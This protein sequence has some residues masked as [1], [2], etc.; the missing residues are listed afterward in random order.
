VAV[1]APLTFFSKTPIECPIC[2][3]K[4][5]R[6]EMRTGR[7]RQ[8]AGSLT[9]EL[10]RNYE[11]SKQ[12]GEVLPL[13][14]PVTV[15][16][17]CYY[18]TYHEDFLNVPDRIVDTLRSEDR[19]RADF[20]KDIFPALDFTEP[21]ALEEGVASY[22]FASMCYEHF[23]KQ[24]SPL[25]KSGLSQ[26]R[27]AWLCQDLHRKQPAEN[28]DYLARVFYRKA[29]Y[30]YMRAVEG[31]QDGSQT[32]SG[33]HTL[34]P[35]LDKNYGYDGVLYISGLLEFQ[36]GPKSDPEARRQALGRAKRTV[37]RIF[38][39]GKASKDKPAAI[40]DNARE[41]YDAISK[42]LGDAD[43]APEV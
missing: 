6:E 16:P 4:V 33:A 17:N 26:L 20:F 30:Y 3:G 18:A 23:P 15:C 34:G 28:F 9:R 11:V 39:M 42:E 12:F 8:I 40:L 31:E 24:F 1:T 27:A 37:A 19:A 36:Y 38:G 41:V 22:V 43:S 2:E 5:F 32:L 35:D 25:F 10:R 7:G 14:Y 13:I 21:R 29:R